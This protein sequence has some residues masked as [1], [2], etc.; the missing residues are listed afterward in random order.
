MVTAKSLVTYKI[1]YNRPD[2]KNKH[3]SVKVAFNNGATQTFE[4]PIVLDEKEIE[5]QVNEQLPLY[6]GLA[7][8]LVY[9]GPE[10]FSHYGTYLSGAFQSTWENELN[11][12]YPQW[13]GMSKAYEVGMND[14]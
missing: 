14:H 10:K 3:K 1:G 12:N 2:G 7:E 8:A 9:T 11:D 4:I 13:K 5:F 6:Y